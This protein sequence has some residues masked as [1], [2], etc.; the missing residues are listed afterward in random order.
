M[1]KLSI[2]GFIVLGSLCY[3]TTALSE[4][5]EHYVKPA[6]NIQH[7]QTLNNVPVYFVE[8]DEL[9]IIDT[10]IVVNAGSA[11]DGA[12]PGLAY[13]TNKM[14]SA[15]A[16]TEHSFAELG[17]IFKRTVDRDKAVFHLRTTSNQ[18]EFSTA[19][20][21]LHSLLSQPVLKEQALARQKSALVNRLKKHADSPRDRGRVALYQLLYQK[22]PYAHSPYGTADSISS[23]LLSDIAAFYRQYY[24]AA[25]L[26][27]IIVGQLSRQ[28]ASETAEQLSR[29]FKPG[30]TAPPIALAPAATTMQQQ[31]IAHPSSQA[32]LFIGHLGMAPTDPD[33]FALAVGNQILGGGA[34]I[35]RLGNEIRL[36]RGLAYKV[37]S[38]FTPLQAKGPFIINIQTHHSQ[39]DTVLNLAQEVL[40]QFIENGPTPAELA[41]AKQKLI[42]NFPLNSDSNEDIARQLIDIGYYQLPLDYFTTYQDNLNAVTIE[43][44]KAA[45]KRHIDPAKLSITITG[46][47]KPD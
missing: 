2:Y 46:G 43:Q 11:H 33:Y 21:I 8:V 26:H 31:K 25:N 15:S 5:K 29:I 1:R 13:L 4:T 35:S 38:Y 10:F 30:V 9:P 18:Q 7:W 44:V 37:V 19:L 34:L 40:R 36:K 16:K 17:A 23:I 28:Q 39:T 24:V 3:F 32:H 47:N 41:A 42:G 14:L 22:H 27:I 12:K 45:F 20:H 6:V